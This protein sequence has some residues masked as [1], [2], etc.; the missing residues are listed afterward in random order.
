M[1]VLTLQGL[2]TDKVINPLG[3]LGVVYQQEK[4]VQDL[5]TLLMT[6]Y[7]SVIGNPTYGSK[8][9]EMLFEQMN[10]SLL[11]RVTS[12]IKTVI[13]NNYNFIYN[14][15]VETEIG[16]KV[17][18]VTVKY[19]TLNTELLTTLEFDIPLNTRGGIKYE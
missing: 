1:N 19:S 3:Q 11:Q 17:L 7:G 12:E 5:Q 14:V 15:E 2:S 16:D 4:L 18:H 13:E 10:D 9:H 8:L 6:R